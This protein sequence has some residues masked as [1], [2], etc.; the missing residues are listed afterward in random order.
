MESNGT[1]AGLTGS[2]PKL[3]QRENDKHIQRQ[4]IKLKRKDF[5]HNQLCPVPCTHKEMRAKNFPFPFEDGTRTVMG[6]KGSVK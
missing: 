3:V 6:V 1:E 2:L 5:F 4:Q